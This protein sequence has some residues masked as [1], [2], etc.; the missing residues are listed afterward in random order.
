MFFAERLEYISRQRMLEEGG[1]RRNSSRSSSSRSTYGW[2]K[3][4][5]D[6]NLPTMLGMLF[7]MSHST[8]IM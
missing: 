6:A 5:N 4:H 8:W 3:E 7:F 2:I 1:V